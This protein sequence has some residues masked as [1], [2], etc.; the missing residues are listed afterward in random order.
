MTPQCLEHTCP[1]SSEN[2]MP[3]RWHSCRDTGCPTPAVPQE[4][5][6][7]SPCRTVAELEELDQSLAQPDTKHKMVIRCPYWCWTDLS[8]KI[9]KALYIV[10][11]VYL[12]FQQEF[13]G[14][15]G[16]SNIGSDIRRILRRVATNDVLAQYSLRGRRAKKAFAP[17]RR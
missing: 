13:L 2:W 17:H 15:L 4:E 8:Y 9:V 1:A 12:L 3:W 16:G 5:V 7:S 11:I 6:L 14:I 10:W